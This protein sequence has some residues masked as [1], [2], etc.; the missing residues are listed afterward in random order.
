M[1]LS[2]DLCLEC[3]TCAIFLS[4]SFTLS[5]IARFLSKQYSVN[6]NVIV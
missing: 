5:I 2:K 3:Y 1:K 6:S 4:S